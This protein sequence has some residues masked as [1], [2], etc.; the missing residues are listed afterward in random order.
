MKHAND[1]VSQIR[2]KKISQTACDTVSAHGPT[3]TEKINRFVKQLVEAGFT[4]QN[5]EKAVV[6]F[7]QDDID[8]CDLSNGN[9]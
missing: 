3:A 8:P 6:H 9:M 1:E 5:A 7:G 2:N 4:Q